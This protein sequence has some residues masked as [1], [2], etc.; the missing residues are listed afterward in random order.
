[1]FSL[2]SASIQFQLVYHF[3]EGVSSRL[4]CC[5]YCLVFF[6]HFALIKTAVFCLYFYSL[7][8]CNYSTLVVVLLY[9]YSYIEANTSSI[10]TE[11][12]STSSLKLSNKIS[13]QPCVTYH[14]N[15]KGSCCS[16]R[17]CL[18]WTSVLCSI[19]ETH[20]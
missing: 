3:S 15:H 2:S 6:F 8:V 5:C 11:R 19:T 12:L 20:W 10:S 9:Y 18:P 17:S 7:L 4:S 1:M 13:D 14:F 16:V